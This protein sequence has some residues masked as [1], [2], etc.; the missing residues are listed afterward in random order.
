MIQAV[1]VARAVSDVKL[2]PETRKRLT[3]VL[4]M[5]LLAA[6][7]A[8]QLT[9]NSVASSAAEA[10]AEFHA[11]DPLNVAT[12]VNP[13]PNMVAWWPGDGNANDIAR[14]NNGSLQNGATFTEGKVGRAFSFDGTSWVQ[15][16]DATSL[17]FGTGDLSIDA[18]IKT[19]VSLGFQPIVDKMSGTVFVTG[20]G[21]LFSLF[22]G[23]LVFAMHDGTSL[24]FFGPVAGVADGQ[25][26]HVAVTVDRD[27][28]NGGKLYVDGNVVLTFD[29]TG[30]PGSLSSPASLTIGRSLF[31]FPLF[32]ALFSGAIDEVEMFNRALTEPEVR[33]IFDA[34]SRGKCRGVTAIS[35]ETGGTVT[36]PRTGASATIPPHTLKADVEAKVLTL[37]LRSV[38]SEVSKTCDVPISQKE[39]FPPIPGFERATEV[40][41]IEVNP[42]GSLVFAPGMELKLP[43]LRA[44]RGKITSATEI[45]LF[46]L[47]RS[48][49]GALVFRDTGI[50]MKAIRDNF[51]IADDV[52][53]FGTYAGFIAASGPPV[54]VTSLYFP[55]VIND[56]A[57][58]RTTRLSFVNPDS[59]DPL[60]IK[61][62][63]YHR[64]AAKQESVDLSLIPAGGHTTVFVPDVFPNLYAGSI[65]AQAVSGSMTGLAEIAD[66]FANPTTLAGVEAVK[67][68]QS[69]LIFPVVEATDTSFT[70]IHLF[71]PDCSVEAEPVEVTLRAF[72]KDG[73]PVNLLGAAQGFGLNPCSRFVIASR[74]ATIEPRDLVIPD[75]LD[76]GYV[77][78]QSSEQHPLVGTELFGQ[79]V[80]R[81]VNLAMQNGLPLPTGCLV[82][83]PTKTGCEVDK[84]PQSSVPDAARQHTLYAPHFESNPASAEMIVVNTSADPARVA[85]SSFAE[86]GRFR[87]TYPAT[88]DPLFLTLAPNEVLRTPVSRV[89]GGNPSPGYVR[90]EDPDSALVGVIAN[91]NGE[92]YRTVVALIPDMPELAQLN[93]Q[94]FLSRIQLDPTTANPRLTTGVIVFNPN[95]NP[96]PFTLKVTQR[97][98]TVKTSAQTAI[99]RGAFTRA[100]SSLSLLF[101]DVSD[102][103]VEI[104][105]T[106][107]LSPGETGRLIVI[108]VYRAT[109]PA[110]IQTTAAVGEQNTLGGVA[111][112]PEK[113]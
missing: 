37:D 79:V 88:D 109:T 74:N 25:W 63:A 72:K 50:V 64:A 83:D 45:R 1:R 20:A 91:R 2:L 16:P 35:A 112:G 42:C 90:I 48:E 93:S 104:Q 7:N 31:F 23:S 82:T 66:D 85:F 97:D 36:D 70:E 17:D 32:D 28:T 12:C 68:P 92:R 108:G 103:Y 49:S 19:N 99:A 8:L 47:G 38:T 15:V 71:N 9:A 87:A 102:G 34:D 43:L 27:Q 98:G 69:T 96:V 59:S 33:A 60:Q 84:S 53:P 24:G 3:V 44:S 105:A 75:E 13:P 10:T 89:L 4:L 110:G 113:R 57:N 94:A 46:Q 86:D 30:V 40:V 21:Y 61:L 26:H 100:R 58:R 73:T 29:P 78:V 51:A 52:Q 101:P 56:P 55:F 111:R 106:S 67:T 81:K 41:R 5:V 54:D 77:S 80:S 18:W 11:D 95:N 6:P 107:K 22:S 14:G 62:T 39:T 65:V 76:G